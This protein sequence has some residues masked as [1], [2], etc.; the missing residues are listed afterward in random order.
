MQ[1]PPQPW[2]SVAECKHKRWECFLTCKA[3]YYLVKHFNRIVH[4]F[5]F[6]LAP[7]PLVFERQKHVM[8]DQSCGEFWRH[9]DW[10]NKQVQ[11]TEVFYWSTLKVEKAFQLACLKISWLEWSTG[12]SYIYSDVDRVRCR[13][14]LTICCKKCI[15]IVGYCWKPI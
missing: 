9:Q 5:L 1:K 7:K 11:N 15:F 8:S 10:P 4:C 3:G 13:C 2:L 12:L 14:F 6:L